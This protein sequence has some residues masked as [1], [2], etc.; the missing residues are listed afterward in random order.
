MGRADARRAQKKG[1]RPAEGGGKPKKKGIRRFFTWKLLLAYFLGAIALGMGAF[2]AL[3]LYVDVPGKG[4]EAAKAQSNVYKNQKG[5]IIARLGEVNREEVPLT[6]VPQDVQR[7]VVAAENKNFWTDPGVDLKGT[8]RGILNTVMGRGKQGGSTITQQYVKNYYLD[9]RQTVTRKVKELIISLKVQD[10][11]P[12]EEILAGYLNTSY[13]GRNA[14]GIQAAARAYYGKDVEKIT[15]EEG[16]YLAA[17]LQAPSQYDWASASDAGKRNVE[18]RWN[19]VLDKMVEQKWLDPA[20]RQSMKFQPPGQPKPPAGLTGQN[21]YLVQA[22]RQEMIRDLKRQG[23][24][25]SDFAAGGWTITLSIDPKKQAA[26]EKAVKKQLTDDLDPK[27]RE[28][29][30]HVQPGAVSVDVKTGQVVAMYGGQDFIKHQTSNATRADYQP[31]STFKPLILASALQN[32]SKTQDR[33]PITSSTLYDGTDKRPV[34]DKGAPVGFAPENEDGY[35]ENPVTVQK[36]M[37][38]SVNSVFAQMAVDVGL[39]KVKKTAVELGMKSDFEEVPSLSLGS[40]GASPLEMAGVYATLDNHGKK[41]NPSIIKSVS[42]KGEAYKLPSP[43]T[44]ERVVSRNTADG[45]TG[46]MT[47]VVDD[48]T[49]NVVSSAQYQVAG[50]TGTSDDNKSAWFTGYTPGLVTSVGVFGEGPGGKQVTLQGTGGGGRV[51]GGGYPA[52][53]WASYMSSVFDDDED[54]SKFDLDTEDGFVPPQ[55]PVGTPSAG[56]ST[57]AS[58]GPSSTP[59]SRSQSPSAS[60]SRSGSSGKPT[61]PTGKPNPPTPPTPPVTSNPTNTAT[62]GDTGNRPNGGR[63]P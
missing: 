18:A 31:A 1:S 48:G 61:P 37:N 16:A 47:G 8:A 35:S 23:R 39:A 21:G 58:R 15:L 51:N 22:A 53:I 46:V 52:K 25:E 62:T 38:K 3:Y 29:D 56:P 24:P 34:V 50:K 36:A 45:V 12:K 20:K 10:E 28:V 40:M 59:S 9:Q 60:A 49:A 54:K 4:N 57:G 43:V 33:K 5:E 41:I 30:G 19:Y 42:W 11:K 44:D 27:A 26:L 6:K 7:A 2:Y 17:L 55:A 63:L 32:G 13:F 14:S